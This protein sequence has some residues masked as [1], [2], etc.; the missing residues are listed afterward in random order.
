L[1]G[2]APEVFFHQYSWKVGRVIGEMI[3]T[4]GADTGIKGTR[5]VGEKGE[6]E[7]K[8]D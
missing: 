7:K 4:K 2:R 1:H 5:G 8:G 3:K 6:G